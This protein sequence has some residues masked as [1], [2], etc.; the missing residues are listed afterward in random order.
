M[1][2]M[3]FISLIGPIGPIPHLGKFYPTSGH[4][5]SP[6]FQE[7]KKSGDD[8]LRAFGTSNRLRK[9][10]LQEVLLGYCK[11]FKIIFKRRVRI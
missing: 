1:G 6:L 5:S 10:Y 3:G 4:L 7:I 9:D 8:Y 2:P 11:L